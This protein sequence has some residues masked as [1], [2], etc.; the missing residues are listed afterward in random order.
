MPNPIKEI[1]AAT[2]NHFSHFWLIIFL[3][4]CKCTDNATVKSHNAIPKNIAL[5][6]ISA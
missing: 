6:S 2:D 5:L 3:P 1:P 4:K